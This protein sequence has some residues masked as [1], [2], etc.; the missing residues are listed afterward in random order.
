M[1]LVSALLIASAW[2]CRAAEPAAGRWEGAIEIPGLELPLVI[3]LAQDAAGQWTG[4]AVLPG[5]G[6]KGAPLA[7]IVAGDAGVRFSLKGALGDPKFTAHAGAGDTL[8][9]DFAL[10]GNT[11]AFTLHKTGPPQVEPPRRSNPVARELEGEWRGEFELFG[12]KLRARLTLTNQPAGTAA[13]FVVGNKHD[14]D[15]P[16]DFVTQEG[17][18]LTLDA[19]AY[20]IGYEGR[21]HADNHEIV[22]TFSQGGLE[23][24]LVFHRSAGTNANP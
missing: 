14:T 5:L 8:T 22:G 15:L 12:N 7:D 16:V 10:A 20:G 13:K 6:I 2:F 18:W 24:P 23:S 4:S 1:R 11:A 3:D 17:E 21:F 9:G 19:H